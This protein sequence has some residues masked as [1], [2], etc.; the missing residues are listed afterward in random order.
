MVRWLWRRYVRPFR[1]VLLAA[2]LLMTLEGSMLGAFSWLIKPMFDQVFT[3]QDKGAILWVGLGMSGV[4]ILRAAA[5]FGHRVLMVWAGQRISARLQRDMVGHLLTLDSSFFQENSP[6]S[7]LERVR[8][9]SQAVVAVW[10]RVLSALARDVMALVALLAVAV[11][12]DWVWTLIAVAAAPL[13]MLPINAL[14]G[15]VRRTSRSSRE[16]AANIS[17]R[18]DE[19]FHGINTIKLTGTEAREQGR[20]AAAM[21]RYIRAHLQSATAQGAIVAL[22]DVIAAIGFFGV[23][24]YG[25]LQIIDGEKTIGEFMSFFTAMGLIFDPVRRLGNISGAWQAALASLDRIRA[26]FDTRPTILS[27]ATPKAP[28]AD[29]SQADICLED[30]EF[31]YGET[32]VLDRLG[33]VAEAGKTT[34]LVGPSGAGK[35]TIFHLLTRLADADQG[36]ISIGGIPITEMDLRDLRGLFSVVSQEA[37]LFDESLRDNVLMGL[38]DVDEA[39]LMRALEAAHVTDFLER[40]PAGLDSPAGPRGSNLSGGQR[41]RIAI[42][43][44][45]LRDA[46]ILLLDEATSA[47]D[48][49]SEKLVQEALDRLSQGRTTLVIAHRLATIRAAHRIVVMDHGKVK[50][51]GSHDELLARGGLYADLYRLQFQDG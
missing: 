46:P 4:F 13:V 6:G 2:T 32:R 8:G 10:E 28:P 51:Q 36:K 7:L 30:V 31:S 15:R 21:N 16:E 27:P 29:M 1:L 18:L 37:L 26:V 33:F 22:I 45:I 23:L 25:G 20:I 41:Q 34:A 44:A 38:G 50:D 5:A 17:T 39:D 35:T 12:V 11:S 49:K 14:Y 40:L 24:T 43:R 42:A 47:L 3:A 9:D 19:A 48:A